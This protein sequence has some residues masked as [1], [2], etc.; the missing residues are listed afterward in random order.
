D[1]CGDARAVAPAQGTAHRPAISS[2]GRGGA[3]RR[4]S[5]VSAPADQPRRRLLMPGLLTLAGFVVL[6]GLG[7]WQLE[8][9]AWKEALIDTLTHRLVAAPGDLPARE[10]YARLRSGDDE[11]RHVRFRA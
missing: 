9:K 1:P 8:R 10:D 7:I 3:L 11:F 5:A 6:V 2:Q 4:R